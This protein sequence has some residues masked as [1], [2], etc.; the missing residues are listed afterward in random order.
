M[1]RNLVL[2]T[3][4][5]ALIGGGLALAQGPHRQAE[6]Q[7]NATVEARTLTQAKV[8]SALRQQRLE[9]RAIASQT[10]RHEQAMLQECD[11]EGAEPTARA[12][13]LQRGPRA[14]W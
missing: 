4:M 2:A 12:E 10:A 6:A 7:P 13:R 14:N 11:P 5:S 1:I 8:Q 3:V 9:E